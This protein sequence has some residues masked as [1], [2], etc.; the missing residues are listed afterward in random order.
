MYKDFPHKEERMRSVHNIH[1]S[2]TW[3]DMGRSMQRIYAALD[4]KKTYHQY[5]MI[6]VVGKINNQPITILIDS[7]SIHSY[8]N[9]NF[10]ERFHFQ[11]SKH[12]KSWL[13]QLANG[14]KRRINEFVMDCSMNMSGLIT[15][16]D[17]NIIP[18]GSYDYFVDDCSLVIN[19]SG[20]LLEAVGWVDLCLLPIFSHMD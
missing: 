5:H 10:V 15:L 4:I 13:V 20:L 17:L 19:S 11:R 6:K 12:G 1:E 16:V 8:I 18:L 2:D 7:G 14:A 3:E 9:P